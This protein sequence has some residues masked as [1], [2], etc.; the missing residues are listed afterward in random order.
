MEELG[1]R[2]RVYRGVDATDAIE[3]NHDISMGI[4]EAQK[5]S[6]AFEEMGI[7]EQAKVRSA[8]SIN[9][10]RTLQRYLRGRE[11]IE[12]VVR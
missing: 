3:M 10:S 7:S 9:R 4:D 11:K 2:P 5:N 6:I 8:T 12:T 1:M